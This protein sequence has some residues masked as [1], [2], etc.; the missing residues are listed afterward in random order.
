MDGLKPK[1]VLS[2]DYS[3]SNSSSS[4]IASSPPAKHLPPSTFFQFSSPSSSALPVLFQKKRGEKGV[5]SSRRTA[6]PSRPIWLLA[7]LSFLIDQEQKHTRSDVMKFA[8]SSLR[9]TR[10]TQCCRRHRWPPVVGSHFER[11]VAALALLPRWMI[12]GII[13]R[14]SRRL[15]KE[16]IIVDK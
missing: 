4:V 15:R 3:T 1:S 16:D 14:I 7:S 5:E 8:S 9:R 2:T 6:H 11:S 10:A 13:A 12:E